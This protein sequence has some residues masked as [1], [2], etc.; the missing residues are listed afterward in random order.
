M[1]LFI[2]VNI[3]SRS[4]DLIENKQEILKEKYRDDYKWVKK[5]NW[6]LTLKFIGE[7][8]TLKKENLIKVLKNIDFKQKNEYIQF[9]HLGAFPNLNSAKVIYLGLGKGKSIL[10]NL[11]Q[12]LEKEIVNYNFKKDQRNF[13]PH[14]TLARA[15]SRPLKLKNKFKTK[16][17]V[18]IYAQI[19]SISL[20]QSKLKAEGPEYIELFSI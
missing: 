20:Y 19:K 7:V 13:I 2:G 16:K 3:N 4:K 9:D 14:L 5:D 15:K 12:N 8:S 6:H 10:T 18:N 11:H 1:R 17:F